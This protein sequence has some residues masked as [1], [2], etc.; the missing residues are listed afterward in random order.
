MSVESVARRVAEGVARRPAPGALVAGRFEVVELLGEGA[1]GAVYLAED[2]VIGRKVALK[3]LLA[4]SRKAAA[5]FQTEAHAASRVSSR[6]VAAV[7]DF[8]EDPEFGLYM[9]MELL[10]GSP[11]DAVLL[12]HGEL[13][14]TRA[15]ALG[16]DIAEAL[17]AA[18]E[19][20]VVHRDLK[21]GNVLVLDEG[22]LKVVDFGIARVIADDGPTNVKLTADGMIVGTPIYMSPEAAMG[23]EVGPAADLYALGVMLFEMVTGRPPF[24]DDVIAALLTAHVREPPPSISSV[25]PDLAVPEGFAALIARLLEKDPKRR[26]VSARQVAR[27]L[28]AMSIQVVPLRRADESGA[29]GASVAESGEV[30]PL[31]P[32]R[33]PWVA[34]AIAAAIVLAS[35]TLGALIAANVSDGSAP[36]AAT[37]PI[38]SETAEPH[39]EDPGEHE[40]PEDV[41]QGRAAPAE[42]TREPT[43][44]PAGA[45]ARTGERAPSPPTVQIDVTTRPAGAT[46]RLDGEVVHPPITV[47]SDGAERELSVT[48]RGHLP[49]RRVLTADRD[50]SVEVV[51]RRRPRRSGGRLPVKLREW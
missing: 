11:L 31:N 49:E 20:G 22:G 46:V 51:L 18:H 39:R 35:V 12:A 14:P 24:V 8:G 29:L 2:R 38:A 34:I 48:A 37:A 10:V 17:A 9:V 7:H 30:P 15:A 41:A 21:P 16:A 3:L 44:E 5:R 47:P 6:H 42:P 27:A 33:T 45:T 23:A 4:P 13:D 32:P 28:R 25:R 43:Q 40:P 26:P 50:H 1:M 36:P 19:Q